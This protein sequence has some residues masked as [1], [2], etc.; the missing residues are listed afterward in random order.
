MRKAF[1]LIEL[2][3]V[4]S[5]IA[6]LIAILLPALGKARETAQK[7]QCLVNL[8]QLATAS[9]AFA[10]DNKGQL[11]PGGDN[12]LQIGLYAVYHTGG[13]W[14]GTPQEARF[15]NYRRMGVLMS[16]GYSSAPEILYCPALSEKHEWLRVGGVRPDKPKHA[17][18]FEEGAMPAG[19]VSNNSS[20]FYRETYNGTGYTPGVVPPLNQLKNTLNLDRD[21]SDLVM[22]AD[23]FA[24]P[25]RGINDHH[26]DGYNFVNLDSSGEYYLDPSQEIE[27][28]GGGNAFHGLG[29]NSNAPRLIE[30]AFES[31]RYGELVGQDCARP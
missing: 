26:G 8:K 1:T 14:N 12:G 20:Y 5:I 7:T 9:N 19:T 21:P 29:N 6:L 17:G 31:F 30:R 27:A 23:V 16:E 25:T 18:W 2:L 3:V 28:L 22:L 24:D 4:I 15:G 13:L 11:P 10:V